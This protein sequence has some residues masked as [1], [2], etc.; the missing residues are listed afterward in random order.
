MVPK[1]KEVG[2][3]LSLVRDLMQVVTHPQ[4]ICLLLSARSPHLLFPSI[5]IPAAHSH[6]VP[7]SA[8]STVT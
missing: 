7:R 1:E 4:R 8:S 2:I 6:S 3:C 5:L